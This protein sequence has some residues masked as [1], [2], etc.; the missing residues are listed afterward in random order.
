MTT[1][2]PHEHDPT[3]VETVA[4]R[5]V[6]EA[7]SRLLICLGSG[8][9]TAGIAIYTASIEFLQMSISASLITAIFTA[10]AISYAI[11]YKTRRQEITEYT[12]RAE[13]VTTRPDLIEDHLTDKQ[14]ECSGA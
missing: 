11:L 14:G 2:Y 9:I 4:D 13:L 3:V 5:W 8:L 12:Q 6:Q 7:Q 1:R 10:C